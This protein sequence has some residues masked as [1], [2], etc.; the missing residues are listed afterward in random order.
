M[1]PPLQDIEQAWKARW[2]EALEIWSH[3]TRL[4]EPRW[5]R[6]DAEAREAHL[7]GSF[8]MIR[9]DDQGVVVNLREVRDLGL[10]EFP[11]EILGHE[12][13]HHVYCPGD[14][15]DHGRLIA[16]VR[17]GL[18]MRESWAGDIAN[19]YADLL[20]NNRLQ[21]SE[22]L[23][24][25]EVYRKLI[26]PDKKSTKLWTLYMRMC[27]L[28]WGVERG[29]LAGGDI[30]AAVE[31]DAQ[32]GARL[33]RVYAVDWVRGG[34]RFAALCL[35]YLLEDTDESL[36]GILKTLGDMGNSGA[37][38]GIPAGLAEM[39][40]EEEGDGIHPSE[41]PEL[42]GFPV[43]KNG[44]QQPSASTLA[45]GSAGN[46]REPFQY[47]Q[48]LKALGLNLSDH[49]IAV[50]YYRERA[51]PHLIPF[52]VRTIPPVC[53]VLPEGAEPWDLGEDLADIDWVETSLA[54]PRVI[55]GMTTRKR[56]F[57]TME[58]ETPKTIPMDLDLYVDCS[59][60]MPNPQ[61][62]TSFLTLA[63]AVIALSALRVG[64]RVQATLWSGANEFQ[65]T[66]GF[67]RDETAV[68]RILTGYLGGGTAFPIHVLRETYRDRKPSDRAVHILVISDDGVTTMFNR[69][70]RLTEGKSV[71]AGALEKA[72]GGGTFCLNLGGAVAGYAGLRPAVAMGWDVQRVATWED[73]VDFAKIFSRKHYAPKE[74]V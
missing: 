14:L 73:L 74:T 29:T 6:S 33:A 9:L 27:E 22:G 70:E 43:D 41:D 35:P 72:R 45:G 24:M 58:G 36:K 42:G 30:P 44:E 57:G 55:P 52:P 32:L 15:A 16:R 38:G 19:I 34:G 61:V 71:A 26:P 11:L 4:R 51:I 39:D 8:A 37:Q 3:Y 53:D 60:S 68:L 18:P 21:R 49:D 63:G 28:L 31:G 69:D 25:A 47:G 13:G 62:T 65:K 12:I 48:I 46:W 40:P 59:G 5:C 10:W 50:A 20:I 17:R 67:V 7:T 54:G 23:R 66:E 64:S 1:T 56:Q 2:P